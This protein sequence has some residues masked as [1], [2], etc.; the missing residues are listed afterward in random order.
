MNKKAKTCLFDIRKAIQAIESFLQDVP[1]FAHYI[2]DLKTRSAIER[3]LGIIGEAINNFRKA[4]T[5]FVLT[6]ARDFVDFRNSL[7]HAYFR[8]DDAAV[9]KILHDRLPPL[10]Q[11]VEQGLK[12]P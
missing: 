5:V 2:A 11:E 9:W 12:L 10:K 4:E 8:V 3:R 7:I 6:D 1:D